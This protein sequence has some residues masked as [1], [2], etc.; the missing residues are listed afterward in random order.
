ML[1][2][3]GLGGT[4]NL[5]NAAGATARNSPGLFGLGN[6]QSNRGK[7]GMPQG[8]TSFQQPYNQELV[9]KILATRQ[10]PNLVLERALFGSN[11]SGTLDLF[12]QQQQ[13]PPL[14]NSV[15]M[16]L[17]LQQQQSVNLRQTQQANA[18]QIPA[19]PNSDLVLQ[20]GHRV[21]N[22]RTKRM[23]LYVPSDNESISPY[24]CFARQNIELFQAQEV[25]VQTGAQGRNKPVK[26]GQV[27]IRCIHCADLHPKLRTRAAVYYPSRLG[28]LYQVY[29][30]LLR[31][32]SSHA[33]FFILKF[34]KRVSNKSLFR[35]Q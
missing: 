8:W 23:L 22:S 27:G 15:A 31:P 20:P 28:V 10:S 32:L 11:A 34:L 19:P 1:T 7:L 12:L 17:A 16:L 4:A 21:D 6:P 29:C 30:A 14:N 3:F 2:Q 24:Q 33:R 25:D 9:Q 18:T 26:L 35:A 13:G 5:G